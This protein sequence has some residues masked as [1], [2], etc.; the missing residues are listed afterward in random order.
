MANLTTTAY[1]TRKGIKFGSIGIVLFLIFRVAFNA[2]VNYWQETHPP[3]PPPATVGFGKLPALKFPEEGILPSITY[4]LE[5]I[6]GIVPQAEDK[7]N[8]YVITKANPS[9]MGLSQ[10]KI[11]AKKI[12]FTSEPTQITPRLYLFVS[13][14]NPLLTFKIDIINGNFELAYDYRDDQS[15]LA[16]KKL[17]TDEQ[18]ITEARNFLSSLGLL[19]EDLDKGIAKITYLR[20]TPSEIIPVLSYSEADFLRVDL[21][22]QE[23]NEKK[24]LPANPNLSL[25]SFLFSGA[26]SQEKRILKAGY[27]SYQI[28]KE[29]FE[30]YPLKSSSSAW[31]ELN[32]GEGYVAELGDNEE[33]QIT[34]RKIYLA[35]YE[36][37]ELQDF[38]QP[39]FVFEGDNGFYAYVS[40][41]DPQWVD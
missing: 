18:A 10:A 5:T 37:K 32:S 17:P 16:E 12:G 1:Y 28:E 20:F 3:P 15:I 34:I 31:T 25:I 40:G 22:R 4:K 13:Q 30:T 7:T 21:F 39:I 6:E 35:Y 19:S 9:L 8:V 23:L 24:V 36:S 38:L 2:V 27:V 11:M 41:V 29:N 33:G 14:I 26:R